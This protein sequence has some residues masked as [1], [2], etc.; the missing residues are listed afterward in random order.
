MPTP[1]PNEPP[2][3][4]SPPSL[5]SSSCPDDVQAAT[6]R[7]SRRHPHA[8]HHDVDTNVQQS[9]DESY[10]PAMSSRPPAIG[11]GAID[12]SESTSVERIVVVDEPTSLGSS[13]RGTTMSPAPRS[14]TTARTSPLPAPTDDE[15]TKTIDSVAD[16]STPSISRGHSV[17]SRRR[18]VTPDTLRRALP[19]PSVHHR[20]SSPADSRVDDCLPSLPMGPG[21]SS[22]RVSRRIWCSN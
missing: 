6:T 10:A 14:T 20:P 1:S 2:N 21:Y 19:G 17:S 18:T 7:Q 15:S 8:R 4:P 12:D 16:E 3:P 11:S 22:S 5:S 9:P 13:S